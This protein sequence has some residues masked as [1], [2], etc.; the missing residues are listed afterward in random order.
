MEPIGNAQAHASG[1]Q[2]KGSCAKSSALFCILRLSMRFLEV[3]VVVFDS[4]NLRNVCSWEL[5]PK[6]HMFKAV[7]QDSTV[8]LE[9]VSAWL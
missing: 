8:S 3:F 7:L 9:Q 6:K 2:T 4:G 5:Q 1:V